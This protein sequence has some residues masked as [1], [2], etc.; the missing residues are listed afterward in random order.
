MWVIV[1]GSST[2]RSRPS[3]LFVVI[4]R[5]A[6]SDVRLWA[7]AIASRS[8]LRDAVLPVASPPSASKCSS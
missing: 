7:C 1:A 4:F 5:I 2:N 3:S 6:R 8:T